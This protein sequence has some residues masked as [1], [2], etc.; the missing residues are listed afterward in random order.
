MVVNVLADRV[1]LGGA[2]A[3]RAA[4]I[5]RETIAALGAARIVTA[6]GASQFEFLKALTRAPDID[7]KKVEMFHLDEYLGLPNMHPAS[8]RRYLRERFIDLVGIERHHL[9]DVDGDER[10]AID[11]VSAAIARAP[12]DLAFVG[13]GEN[14]HLAFNDP[15][16]DFDTRAPYIVVKLDEA[17]RRQQ[18]GE[19]WF[20]RL[21][22]VPT[23][24]VSMSVHQILQ[25]KAILCIAPDRRKAQAVAAC[26]RGAVSPKVPASALQNHPNT[27]LY[28]DQDSAALLDRGAA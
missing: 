17:C 11:T 25:A 4:A 13:I 24:A 7:W 2:A 28:L 10:A 3:D 1:A 15:P 21:E 6:T 12:I 18:V 9:L 23:R 22:E 5:L 16:A 26:L 14:G 20:S 27:T 19:G 8:F